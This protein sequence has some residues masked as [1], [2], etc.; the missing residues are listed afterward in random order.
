MGSCFP[1]MSRDDKPTLEVDTEIQGNN[2]C[3]NINDSC[4]SS[5]CIITIYQ[6]KRT[7]SVKNVNSSNVD[8]TDNNNKS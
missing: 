3:D 5:C 7:D 1:C 4:P 2:C 8:N 6:V